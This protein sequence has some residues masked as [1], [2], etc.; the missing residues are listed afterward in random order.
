MENVPFNTSVLLSYIQKYT[1]IFLTGLPQ[2]FI[3]RLTDRAAVDRVIFCVHLLWL[4]AELHFTHAHTHTCTHMY[5]DL[6]EVSS[7][8]SLG[9]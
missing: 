1:F 8:L 3:N 4:H 7:E 5:T 6:L 2:R 9:V